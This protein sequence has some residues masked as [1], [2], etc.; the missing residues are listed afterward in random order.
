MRAKDAL[1]DTDDLLAGLDDVGV[2][3]KRHSVMVMVMMIVEMIMVKK[4]MFCI[5]TTT[6]CFLYHQL[7]S[8]RSLHLLGLA[9]PTSI[10]NHTPSKRKCVSFSSTTPVRFCI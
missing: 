2:L 7:L 8:I 4:V 10:C 9:P 3:R 6:L 1:E 5:Y